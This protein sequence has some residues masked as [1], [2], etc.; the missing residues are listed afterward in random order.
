MQY[1]FEV[2]IEEADHASKVLGGYP[3]PD[4]EIWVAIAPITDE[5]ATRAPANKPKRSMG[6]MSR[7]AQAGMLCNSERFQEFLD[8]RFP[9]VEKVAKENAAA[10][11]RSECRSLRRHLDT[12]VDAGKRWDQLRAEYDVWRRAIAAPR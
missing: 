7:T 5:A 12:D 3:R 4:A 11:V 1:I 2:P 6:D 9:R 10:I 8:S